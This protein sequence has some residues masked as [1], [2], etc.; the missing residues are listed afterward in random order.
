[1]KRTLSFL[2]LFGFLALAF[3][4]QVLMAQTDDKLGE[5]TF[6]D[7]KEKEQ[8][9]Q[10]TAFGGGFSG[11]F[12]FFNKDVVNSIPAIYRTGNF[13]APLFIT[14]GEGFVALPFLKNIRLGFS[15]SAGT[16][17]VAV[18]DTN[19]ELTVS[20]N[21]L[22][23]DYAIPIFKGFTILPGVQGG[24]GMLRVEQYGGRKS[25]TWGVDTTNFMNRIEATQIFVQPAVN[26]EYALTNLTMLRLNVGYNA[27]F[28][29][30]WRENRTT[31]LAN[32]NSSLNGNGLVIGFGVFVGLFRN[33]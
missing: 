5:I 17:S 2:T 23:V 20:M 11:N 12:L 4:T 7:L 24:W 32:P 9:A 1:M 8:T 26:F 33:E 28:I 29:G 21:G 25:G 16:Q 10:Y 31:E 14:G 19:T 6:E 13:S 3:C 27:S 30:T 15:G 22:R 18:G